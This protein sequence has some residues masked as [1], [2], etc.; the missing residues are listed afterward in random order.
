[1]SVI[2][3]IHTATIY[4]AKKSKAFEGQRLV[5]TI[6]KADSKGNYGP[7]LQ[8]TMC[9]SIPMLSGDSLIDALNSDSLQP[10]LVPHLVSFMRDCQNKMISARIK[11][12]KKDITS[13]ELEIENIVFWLGQESKGDKWDS[14]RIASWFMESLAEHVGIA[15]I[16]KG[17]ED[18]DVEKRLATYCKLF[19]SAL[20]SKAA[21][22]RKVA[23]ELLKALKLSPDQNDVI[24]SRFTVRLNKVLEE[25]DLNEAFGL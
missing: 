6:A 11:E 15:L 13:E 1:M 9:T 23:S 22:P 12:G 8:Q 21:I 3:N 17:F 2:S 20:S 16:Q 25:I 5:V 4:D 14:E 24:V 7:N 10:L 18:S 19:S